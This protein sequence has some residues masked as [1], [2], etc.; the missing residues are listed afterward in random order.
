MP[1]TYSKISTYLV[2]VESPA[3]CKKIE[4]YLG[5]GYRCVASF[6][7]LRE[8]NSLKNVDIKNNFEP[9]FTNI[10]NSMKL[11]RI[12]ELRK[13]IDSCDDVI[14]ATDDD[15]EGEAIAWHI[16]AMFNLNIEKTKRIVFHEITENAIQHAIK[17]SRRVNMN[18]VHAQ[19]ARQILDLLVGFKISPI[20]WKYISKNADNCLSAGRCQTPALRI[21][22]ENQKEIEQNP[23]I[24]KYNTI[25]YFTNQCIAFDLSKKYETDDEL[26]DFLE[27][28][29]DF[30]H[31]YSC[32]QPV[33][34]YKKEPEPFTTSRLQQSASNDL[35]V[36]P[37]ETMRLCQTLYE[38]GYIT[39]MRTD[40][41]TYSR[42]FI[43]STKKYIVSVYG[44]NYINKDIDC[45]AIGEG[46]KKEKKKPIS[47]KVEA[48]EAHEAI[49][50]TNILLKDLPDKIGSKEKRMYKF[51][52]ENTLESC[53]ER[54]SFFSIT[55]NI[56]ASLD[57]KFA[58]TSENVDFLGWKIVKGKC[59]TDNKEYHYLLQ[60]KQP[61]ELP[62]KKIQSKLTLTNTKM[63]YTEAKLVQL[64]EENG[65]GR[66]STFSSLV[67]KIQE[68]GY[69]AKED[70]Q[71]N[72]IKCTDYEM[73][74]SEIFEIE[75]M[76]EF[77]N[78][79]NKLVIQQV[80]TLVS[81][82]LDKNFRALFNYDYTKEMENN[83]DKVAKGEKVWYEVCALCLEQIEVLIQELK[84]TE[85]SKREIRIDNRHVYTIGK[86]GPVIKCTDKDGEGVSF[87]TIKKDI[88]LDKLEAGEY[89][90]EDI[91]AEKIASQEAS[92]VLGQHEG[93]DVFLKN[94]KFGLYITW[95]KNT[96]SLK[97]FGN[98]PVEN[99]SFEDIVK[100][101]DK[102]GNLVREISSTISI[103]NGKFGRYIFYKTQKMKKPIFHQLSGFTNDVELCDI[104]TIKE[105]I[106]EK[107]KIR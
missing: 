80:G 47:I 87:K 10:E 33:K 90:L 81:Q 21:I 35:H 42:D 50:P 12:A 102:D 37:K 41:K 84:E 60:M 2:I 75:T 79:K 61:F 16:C 28:S 5:P 72:K 19:Q 53:M 62:C 11:K 82:F 77:G 18:I 1:K 36:S 103:R 59:E 44:A 49:R 88:D 46:E 96:K 29:I 70:I 13:E 20:L 66:P 89:K 94:G 24:K 15:R 97:C 91:V 48:Q 43:E 27:R 58:Y 101:L 40:S 100:I 69:V 78:E 106:E 92:K 39:Y 14:L 32:S 17:N 55:A 4:D 83:L 64:L 85:E 6:G 25:G 95:G 104:N 52:W 68:R 73:E 63:H 34:V 45:H 57:N 56:T 7:H 9:T 51:I 67:D 98:R 99:I 23:G 86:F 107:Y 3:K 26:I 71:G 8:L 38:A 93:E 105:W 31:V 54:A 30:K 76:R 65:I 22:Y 74:N